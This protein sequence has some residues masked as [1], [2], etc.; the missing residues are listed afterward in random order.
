MD[1]VLYQNPTTSLLN[2]Y[3]RSLCSVL[4]LDSIIKEICALSQPAVQAANL[5]EG[6]Q[7]GQIPMKLRTSSLWLPR[8]GVPSHGL[9]IGA[10]MD[11]DLLLSRRWT[12]LLLLGRSSSSL[13]RGD[14]PRKELIRSY[15]GA[16]LHEHDHVVVQEDRECVK[17]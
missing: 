5:M 12:T 17:Q 15:T 8:R 9:K 4:G 2:H 11:V 3:S 14:N 6:R 10:G 16:A 13:S 1:K 7:K